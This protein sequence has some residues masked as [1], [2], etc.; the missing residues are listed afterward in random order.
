MEYRR[1]GLGGILATDQ[2]QLTSKQRFDDGFLAWLSDRHG[3]DDVRQRMTE[4]GK[5]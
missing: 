3:L 5:A 1:I 2:Y 4:R